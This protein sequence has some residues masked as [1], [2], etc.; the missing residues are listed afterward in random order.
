MPKGE[1]GSARPYLRGKIYWIKYYVDGK[2]KYESSRSEKKSDALKLLNQKRA[3]IDTGQLPKS[4]VTVVQLLNLYL[5]DLQRNKRTYYRSAKGYVRLHL[6]P[7]FSGKLASSVTSAHIKS[8]IDMRQRQQAADG[9][10]NRELACLNRSYVI[11]ME[12]TPPLIQRKPKIEKLPEDNVREGFLEH[13]EYRR[14]IAELPDH[15]RTILVIGFHLGLRLG[16]IL[17]LKWDQV[18]WLNNLLILSRKQTKGKQ[19]RK[20]PLYGEL[21][22]WLEMAYAK[23]TGEYIVSYEGHAISEIKRAWGNARKRARLPQLLVHD[24]RRTAVRNMVRAG[25]PEKVAMLIS[26][27]KTRSVFERYNI[28]D[29]RDFHLAGEMLNKYHLS[30]GD[31]TSDEAVFTGQDLVD[32]V[33]NRG[34]KV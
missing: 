15:Q 9:S 27:H 2:P 1:R 28:V 26:G 7:A 5:A 31:K 11:A 21:R 22:A 20:A 12:S 4:D 34:R 23:R 18:D 30:A 17:K 19:A 32:Q 10:I 29:E 14:M 25:I 33:P 6:I 13:A 8:Y 16:E 24:L 3:Q